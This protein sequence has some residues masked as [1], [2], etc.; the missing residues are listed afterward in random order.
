M[1]NKPSALEPVD[2][3]VEF[4][5]GVPAFPMWIEIL[6]LKKRTKFGYDE[7]WYKR[8][9]WLHKNHSDKINSVGMTTNCLLPMK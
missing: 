7:E 4:D 3:E 2:E 6:T 9:R 5:T 1:R 8:R